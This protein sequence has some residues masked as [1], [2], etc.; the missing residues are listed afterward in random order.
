MIT[1]IFIEQFKCFSA[2]RLGLRPLSILSGYNGGGKSSFIQPLLLLSQALMRPTEAGLPLNGL[3][4]RLGTVAD[5]LN[6]GSPTFAIS[7]GNEV[8][9]WGFDAKAGERE[10]VV[11]TASASVPHNTGNSAFSWSNQLLPPTLAEANL[12]GNTSIVSALSNLILI[13]A[14]RPGT[15]DVQP[16]PD[17]AT[18]VRGDVGVGGQYASYWYDTLVDEEVAPSLRLP[19]EPGKTMRMQVDAYLSRLFS[20]AQA[21]VTA[22][23]QASAYA[24]RYRIGNGDLRRPANIGYGFTHAF[25]IIIALLAARPHQIVVVDSPEAH[26][27]PSAQSQMGRLLAIVAA[28]GVQLLIETHSDHLLNGIRLAVSEKLI[29][30]THVALHFFS[31]STNDGH[32]VSSPQIDSEGTISDWP[33][34]FFDQGEADLARLAGWA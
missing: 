14:T 20:G 5:V 28:S 23:P 22:M 18:P 31:G 17:S 34:G 12:V 27:H 11:K 8:L 16:M 19:E 7:S 32:G 29:S 30:P 21:N 4:A 6:G 33:T 25:P 3:L 1:S 15:M 24:L 10:L 9:S 26:L 2:I 13:T